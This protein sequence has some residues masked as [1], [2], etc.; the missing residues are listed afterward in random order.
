ML[1]RRR[2]FDM[3]KNVNKIKQNKSDVAL[4]IVF[5]ALLGVFALMCVYPFYQVLVSSFAD[6]NTLI[7]EG[8]RL[9]P[10]KFSL[11][12]YRTIFAND[13]IPRAYLVTVFITVAGTALSL[14]VTSLAAYA[15]SGGK[16]KYRNGISLFFYFT[17]LFSGGLVANY[18]LITNYLHLDNSIWVYIIPACFNVW[19]MFLLRNFFNEIP[20]SL[21]ES[22]KI[23][24]ASEGIIA[25]KIVLPLSLPAMATIG[26]F[27]A[28]GFWN[29]W[30]ASSLYIDN[31][32]LYTLQYIIVRMVNSISAAQNVGQ[33]GLPAGVIS[34]PANTIR[35]ATAM[36]TVGPIVLLYP[37]LQKY[38]VKG[39]RVGGVKE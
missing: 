1:R 13:V 3:K 38:F 34:V 6:E 39:L 32:K 17:C 36:V 14:I 2:C 8:Y 11:D 28:L 23:D 29:E 31:E 33:A 18:L 20:A 30:M 24:G 5:Y 7:S 12:A 9:I 15:L 37:F 21:I 25:F 27:T 10:S 4:N 19:N 16:L 35:L 26:L 22:A